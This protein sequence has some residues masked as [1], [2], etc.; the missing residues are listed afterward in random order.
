M[1]RNRVKKAFSQG[2]P[3]YDRT[4][5]VQRTVMERLLQLLDQ[6]GVDPGRI[7]DIGAGTGSLALALHARYPSAHITCLDLAEG[8]VAAA[9]EK[10]AHTKALVLQGDAEALPFPASAY[11]LVLSTSTLQWL[12]SQGRAFSEARRVMSPGGHFVFALFGQGTLPELKECHAAACN[13]LSAAGADRPPRFRSLCQVQ[14]D[15]AAAGF[16]SCRVWSER[17][18]EWYGGVPELLKA[19]KSIGAG[20]TAPPPPGLASRRLLSRTDELYRERYG[21]G[22]GICA[23]YE[24]IYGI[25]QR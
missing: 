16:S 2:A 13:E 24:V 1:D 3:A 18:R 20:S 23:S 14:E 9:R 11:D 12:D 10:L 25:A 17:E 4:V 5:R 15:L 8:M 19:L 21:E 6:E 7:V 22:G